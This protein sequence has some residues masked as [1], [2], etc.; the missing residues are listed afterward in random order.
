MRIFIVKIPVMKSSLFTR[1]RFLVKYAPYRMQML[2]LRANS[3]TGE[4][5]SCTVADPQ[6]I[7]LALQPNFCIRFGG[8]C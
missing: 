8:Y 5:L 6:K 1:V 2:R 7:R 3:F 4:R